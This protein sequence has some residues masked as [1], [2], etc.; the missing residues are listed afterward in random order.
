MVQHRHYFEPPTSAN[1]FASATTWNVVESPQVFD[2]LTEPRVFDDGD[3][4]NA[5]H[6]VYVIPHRAVASMREWTPGLGMAW[7][8]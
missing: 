7:R 4:L 1:Q 3:K 2:P 6:P 8:T 5:I